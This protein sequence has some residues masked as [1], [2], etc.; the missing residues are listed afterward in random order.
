MSRKKNLLLLFLSSVMTLLYIYPWTNFLFSLL[1][2]NSVSFS[3][4]AVIFLSA[5]ALVFL[6]GILCSRNITVLLILISGWLISVFVLFNSY[7]R[8]PVLSADAFNFS[9]YIFPEKTITGVLTAMLLYGLAAYLWISAFRVVKKPLS[10][11]KV[12]HHF[13]KGL[14]FILALLLLKLLIA[15]KGGGK[16]WRIQWLPRVQPFRT[17]P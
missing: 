17:V 13:D 5:S 6:S 4:L 15:V 11:E 14:A 3:V 7:F 2:Y 10:L 16:R 8:L 9:D 12:N 1:P